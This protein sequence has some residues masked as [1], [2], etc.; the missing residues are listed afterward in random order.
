MS[1]EVDPQAPRRPTVPTVGPVLGVI[2]GVIIFKL[3]PSDTSILVGLLIVLVA[4]AA[5]TYGAIEYA[6]WKARR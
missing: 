6:R 3:L 5:A 4:V 1:D 2:I